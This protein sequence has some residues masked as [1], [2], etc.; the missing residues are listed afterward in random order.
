MLRA[1]LSLKTVHLQ[2]TTALRSHGVGFGRGE[3]ELEQKGCSEPGKP[4]AK[5]R[6]W[7][8]RRL[9]EGRAARALGWKQTERGQQDRGRE[10]ERSQEP[11]FPA[12]RA[13][14]C[15]RGVGTWCS[16]PGTAY[17]PMRSRGQG[18]RR[19][20]AGGTWLVRRHGD[21]NTRLKLWD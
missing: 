4:C 10:Q 20:L 8:S 19:R 7:A 1:W 3:Q 11:G 6:R 2:H 15:P 17:A 14:G 13:G 16:A 21:I 18:G 9:H 5:P 12:R